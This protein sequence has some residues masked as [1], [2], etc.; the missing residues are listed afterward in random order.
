MRRFSHFAYVIVVALL[1]PI[2]WA[3]SLTN[4]DEAGLGNFGTS[5]QRNAALGTNGPFDCAP[6]STVNSF[7][8]LQSRYGV[9]GLVD[10]NPYDTINKLA[11]PTYM[12]VQPAIQGALPSG[13]VRGKNRA[14]N[15]YNAAHPNQ[16]LAVEG[17][18]VPGNTIPANQINPLLAADLSLAG[19]Q[20]GMQSATPS[21]DFL[22]DELA[23]GQDIELGIL[24][25]DAAKGVY[26]GGHVVTATGLFNADDTSNTGT[27][28]FVDPW[29]STTM[30]ASLIGSITGLHNGMMQLQFSGGSAGAAGDPDN[31]D[32]VGTA[33]IAFVIAESPL[34]LP[35][36]VWAGL[37]LFGMVAAAGSFNRFKAVHFV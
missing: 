29:G 36:S 26:A 15:E 12:N 10:P 25:F 34:P 1:A 8:Y 3:A 13:I 2:S 31:F 11:G 27:L 9:T 6:T 23:K 18:V 37:L 20:H 21:I 5:S 19:T 16:P 17:Q 30:A 14:I 4:V 7:A 35:S 22:H 28:D 32:S 33:D 24:W